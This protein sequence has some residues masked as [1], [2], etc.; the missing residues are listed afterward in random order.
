LS[1]GNVLPYDAPGRLAGTTTLNGT[2]IAQ[3]YDAEGLRSSYSVT[4]VGQSVPSLSEQFQ[5]AGG[6]LVQ[7]SRNADDT[8]TRRL[9]R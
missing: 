4:G 1:A 7:A 6:Q 5:Y 3:S 2:A 8:D 9:R